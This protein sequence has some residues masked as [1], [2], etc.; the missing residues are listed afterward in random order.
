M[1]PYLVILTL[2][3]SFFA[4]HYWD[5]ARKNADIKTLT[6]LNSII[7]EKAQIHSNSYNLSVNKALI[8][9][10]DHKDLK[11][12]AKACAKS[13]VQSLKEGYAMSDN[14]EYAYATAYTEYR[15]PHREEIRRFPTRLKKN[16]VY[17]VLMDDLE[18]K[19]TEKFEREL[20]QVTLKELERRSLWYLEHIQKELPD[21]GKLFETNSNKEHL[22]D[23]RSLRAITHLVPQLFSNEHWN[24]KTLDYI[25]L[26][27]EKTVYWR[28]DSLIGYLASAKA[29]HAAMVR[30]SDHPKNLVD[31]YRKVLDPQFQRVL[32]SFL[33]K[34]ASAVFKTAL[35]SKA[36]EKHLSTQNFKRI[37]N[38]IFCQGPTPYEVQELT[39]ALEINAFATE[40]KKASRDFK[41]L[42]CAELQRSTFEFALETRI[43]TYIHERQ[44]HIAEQYVKDFWRYDSEPLNKETLRAKYLAMTSSNT[45]SDLASSSGAFDSIRAEYQQLSKLKSGL[46]GSVPFSVA[47][48]EAIGRQIDSELKSIAQGYAPTIFAQILDRSLTTQEA[49]DA[50]FAHEPNRLSKH[51]AQDSHKSI[52]SGPFLQTVSLVTQGRKETCDHTKSPLQE[53]LGF[54]VKVMKIPELKKRFEP[55]LL[56]SLKLNFV[57]HASDAV[58][59]EVDKVLEQVFNQKKEHHF[60]EGELESKAQCISDQVVRLVSAHSPKKQATV[61]ISTGSMTK[62]VKLDGLLKRY[63]EVSYQASRL[64]I[65]LWEAKK[66]VKSGL[67]KSTTTGTKTRLNCGYG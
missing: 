14:F 3:V 32:M 66:L 55:H 58:R 41:S 59:S 12:E 23:L 18:R 17:S 37:S 28:E 29:C 53:R 49:T 45:H 20:P 63:L 47:F 9:A 61:S 46:R 13:L 19:L 64:N 30:L 39:K 57:S 65:T 36:S 15:S 44:K 27:S 1:K 8:S 24:N 21:P 4:G 60:R 56:A 25:K 26:L 35:A 11:E 43:S 6:A 50:L 31:N 7:F 51:Q 42:L 34:S 10:M 40:L 67:G 2:L 38:D 62:E 33:Q 48:D 22:N 16:A 52:L 54:F 5:S